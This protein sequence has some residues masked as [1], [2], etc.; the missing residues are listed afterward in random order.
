MIIINNRI[1]L[2][3]L[4]KIIIWIIRLFNEKF[5]F[6]EF[7]NFYQFCIEITKS[8]KIELLCLIFIIKQKFSKNSI[9]NLLSQIITT[10][11]NNYL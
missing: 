6:S 4:M 3:N 10:I 7:I 5:C 1:S 8:T 9:L 11:I 2:K